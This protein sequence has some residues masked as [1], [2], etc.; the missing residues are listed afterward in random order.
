MEEVGRTIFLPKGHFYSL[1]LTHKDH[2]KGSIKY[3]SSIHSAKAPRTEGR[4]G[5][6]SRQKKGPACLQTESSLKTRLEPQ[7]QH[8]LQEAGIWNGTAPSSPAS[9]HTPFLVKPPWL[10]CLG[11]P[12]PAWLGLPLEEGG[13]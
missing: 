13:V 3:H 12:R 2:L 11:C 7:T 6:S 1:W 10:P 8:H 4:E 5:S 9:E